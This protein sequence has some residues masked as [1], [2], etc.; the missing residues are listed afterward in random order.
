MMDASRSEPP[1]VTFADA[2]LRP[3][4]AMVLRRQD[5]GR[6]RSPMP[7]HRSAM[8]ARRRSRTTPTGSRAPTRGW[9]GQACGAPT[10]RA[11]ETWHQGWHPRWSE[12]FP[13][14]GRSPHEGISP[15]SSEGVRL[16]VGDLEEGAS[17][18]EV[19]LEQGPHRRSDGGATTP[20]APRGRRGRA[21]PRVR[22][23][24]RS[25]ANAPPWDSCLR[26]GAP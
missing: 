23:P 25:R 14:R 1:F 3:L 15:A 13:S 21:P 24:G 6:G 12:R 18:A 16:E 2:G 5:F 11:G 4:E 9:V 19:A 22:R 17:Q 20:G 7:P 26:R 8:P 10:G